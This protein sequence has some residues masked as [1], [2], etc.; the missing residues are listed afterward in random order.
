MKSLKS[1]MIITMC[2]FFVAFFGF[3]TLKV[4][5]ATAD[6]GKMVVGTESE[7]VIEVREIETY[8]TKG[9]SSNDDVTIVVTYSGTIKP[10]ATYY[11]T[12]TENGIK[13]GGT[14]NLVKAN[15]RDGYTYA[16]YT[17]KL[18]PVK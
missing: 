8:S 3:G 14:L 6:M 17:G 2:A 9:V 7:M 1:C 5:A 16:T 18:S 4:E 13:Y 10:P 15:A 12:K 11:Y